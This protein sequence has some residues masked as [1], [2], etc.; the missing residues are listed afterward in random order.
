M[1]RMAEL[2]L[3]KFPV[4]SSNGNE[5]LVNVYEDEFGFTRS[6]VYVRTKGWFGREKF[7]HIFGGMFE[8]GYY[9]LEKWDYDFVRIAKN[10]VYAYESKNAAKLLHEKR[11]AQ[12]VAKF[13]EWDGECE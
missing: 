5:Y 2:Y 4:V 3:E 11:K 9:D 10:T 7:K 12:G 8:G 1:A 6:E 13:N